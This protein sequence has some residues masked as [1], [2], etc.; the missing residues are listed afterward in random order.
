MISGVQRKAELL[1]ALSLREIAARFK[2]SYGGLS[3]YVIQNLLLLTLYSFVF[4]T[5]FKNRWG[6]GDHPSGN[7]TVALFIGLIVFNLFAECV[8][9]AP[10][11]IL[12]NAN[13]VK[14][15]V[16]PL[17]VLPV[18][19]LITAVFNAFVAMLV[20]IAVSWYLDSPM[21]WQ[22]LWIPVILLPLMVLIL[23]VTWLLAALGTYIRDINQMVT[24]LISAFMFLSPLFYQITALPKA[25]QTWVMFNPLTLPMQESRAALMLGQ[26]PDWAALGVYLLIAV[27][28]AALGYMFFQ[29][30]RGGFAD[31]I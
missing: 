13:Y 8:T 25:A 15:V 14:K 5:L 24:L 16:F 21:H 10:T 28:V 18:V 27:P 11:L 23:G 9:R 12:A 7:F 19:T 4:G 30:M 31:V 2:G 6:Q 3:W 1:W 17:D 29:K 20:L 26:S 22:G